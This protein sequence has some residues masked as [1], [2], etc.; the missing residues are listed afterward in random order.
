MGIKLSLYAFVCLSLLSCK[1]YTQQPAATNQQTMMELPYTTIPDYPENYSAAGV[2]ARMVDGLGF[3]YR[4]ATE[5]LTEK[6]LAYAPD[7]TART[8][9]ETM[10]HLMGLSETI[11]N[12]VRKKPNV[13]PVPENN[14][15]WEE[16]RK[17]T[18]DNL[19]ATS[20]ILWSSKDTD[21]AEYKIIFQRGDN[22]SEFPFWHHMNG[23]IADALWHCGQI[24]SFRRA[25]G[26]P[27]DNRVNVFMG[28]LRERK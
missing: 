27:I 25:S 3:R 20:D 14:Y 5:D 6:D 10:D 4:W 21:L 12:A 22:V 11:V 28:K 19:K 13:R 15:T 2:A 8:S 23:P 24:V 9:M 1:T 26:N 17:I 7:S 18:L 16:K